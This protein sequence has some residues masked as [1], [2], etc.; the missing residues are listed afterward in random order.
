MAKNQTVFLPGLRIRM[1]LCGKQQQRDTDTTYLTACLYCI[2][3]KPQKS[4]FFSGP[5]TMRGGGAGVV[6]A[7]PLNKEPFL[8]LTLV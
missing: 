6:R 8:R 1:V 7:G 4:T 3:Y 5:G 2:S